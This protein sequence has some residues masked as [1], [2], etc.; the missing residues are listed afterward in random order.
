MLSVTTPLRQQLAANRIPVQ[1][2]VLRC[3]TPAAGLAASTARLTALA[4]DRLS[5]GRQS[6]AGL[7]DGDAT[8]NTNLPSVQ[9][10]A[11]ERV[12]GVAPVVL[13]RPHQHCR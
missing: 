7:K 12:K 5:V 8:R 11:H 6:S 3:A 4:C 10:N 9:V 13:F 2:A 1:L